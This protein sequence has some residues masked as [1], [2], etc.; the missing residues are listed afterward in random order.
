MTVANLAAAVGFFGV[1][2]V[3]SLVVASTLARREARSEEL[4]SRMGPSDAPGPR[5]VVRDIDVVGATMGTVGRTIHAL[6]LRS[7][8]DT[9]V[10]SVLASAAL[11]GFTFAALSIWLLGPAFFFLGLLPAAVP[12]L[13]LNRKV[14]ERSRTITEQLPDAI[15]LITRALRAGHAFTDAL[16]MAGQ[17][18]PAPIGD[19]L[20]HT[21]EQHRLGLPLRSCLEG[22]IER[23]PDNFEMRFLVSAVLLNRDTG[24]N[25]VEVM[26]TIAETV[27]DRVVF[28]SKV[29]AL[30]AEVRMSSLIL[31]LL[32]FAAALLLMALQPNHLMPL[33]DSTLGR[34]MLA[35]GLVSLATGSV[36]MG[37]ISQVDF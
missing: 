37:R 4:R 28:E 5:M 24:G 15:D 36:V 8:E 25:L 20:T 30:T 9:S 31:Q 29:K 10:S 3:V 22:L 32:P 1:L 17:E 23:L 35:G 21:A 16:L 7:G 6:I 19:E 27:R 2:I 13:S 18:M 26:E 14:A 34:W 12:F 11:A 33:I